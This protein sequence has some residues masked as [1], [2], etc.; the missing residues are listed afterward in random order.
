MDRV[1]RVCRKDVE[2]EDHFLRRC[3]GYVKERQE[4]EEDMKRRMEWTEE[5]M[6]KAW[7]GESEIK[8]VNSALT[9]YVKRAVAKRDRILGSNVFKN[10]KR[11]V[12]YS[13]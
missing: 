2:D 6:E 4:C 10:I 3:E 1:C 9:R 13:Y 11:H 8:M 7:W 5:N 12:M